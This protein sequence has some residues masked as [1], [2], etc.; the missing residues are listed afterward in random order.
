M[1]SNG[2]AEGNYTL[3]ALGAD[4]RTGTSDRSPY[5]EYKK[6]KSHLTPLLPTF[7]V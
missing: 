3:V 7:S 1:D 2:D 6:K 5:Y 4:E